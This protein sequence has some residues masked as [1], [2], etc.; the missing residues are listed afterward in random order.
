MYNVQQEKEFIICIQTQLLQTI[1]IT[2]KLCL[3]FASNMHINFTTNTRVQDQRRE[4]V[5]GGQEARAEAGG[6]EREVEEAGR[7][8][9]EREVEEAGGRDWPGRQVNKGATTAVRCAG[10]QPTGGYGIG[11]RCLRLA[12]GGG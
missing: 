7:P 5:S 4:A 9:L 12:C 11:L 10:Q 3:N 8:W 6:C 1:A 2:S